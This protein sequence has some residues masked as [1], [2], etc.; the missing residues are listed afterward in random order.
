MDLSKADGFLVLVAKK[1]SHGTLEDGE[2]NLRSDGCMF[3]E[4]KSD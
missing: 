3:A 2:N 1:D 4:S